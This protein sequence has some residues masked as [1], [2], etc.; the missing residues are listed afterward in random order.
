MWSMKEVIYMAGMSALRPS[1]CLQLLCL[2]SFNPLTHIN[3]TR[4]LITNKG[5]HV[6]VTTNILMHRTAWQLEEKAQHFEIDGRELIHE[7]HLH[8]LSRDCDTQYNENEHDNLHIRKRHVEV[9][10]FKLCRN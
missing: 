9:E 4:A 2:V 7:T 5:K 3:Q 10:W 6:V 1:Q 8:D